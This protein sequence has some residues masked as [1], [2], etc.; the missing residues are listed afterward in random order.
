M[1]INFL[2]RKAIQINITTDVRIVENI[3]VMSAMDGYLGTTGPVVV[4]KLS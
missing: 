2:M 3:Y 4:N 1:D